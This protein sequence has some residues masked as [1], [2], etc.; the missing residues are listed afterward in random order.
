MAEHA[1]S[2]DKKCVNAWLNRG[3]IHYL[4]ADPD[5]A[6]NCYEKALTLS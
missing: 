4:M 2:M 5:K 6:Q 3:N 1:L